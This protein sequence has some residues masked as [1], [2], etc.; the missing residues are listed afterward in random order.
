MNERKRR[1]RRR[2]RRRWRRR[3]RCLF[4]LIANG[5]FGG[6]GRGSLS[7][8][9]LTN[10]HPGTPTP[11]YTRCQ[12][13]WVDTCISGKA[14][15]SGGAQAH[16]L[17][18]NIWLVLFLVAS[19][20]CGQQYAICYMLLVQLRPI[21]QSTPYPSPCSWVRVHANIFGSCSSLSLLLLC[22]PALL[23]I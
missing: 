13:H 11:I 21:Y 7:R 8:Y 4:A 5:I 17:S 9:K 18:K 6:G 2:R 1:R 23:H 16:K 12:P 10:N 15:N 14:E 3:R 22:F 19:A 20:C